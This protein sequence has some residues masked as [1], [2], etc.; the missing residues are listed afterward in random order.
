MSRY[1]GRTAQGKAVIFTEA[2]SGDEIASVKI[3]DTTSRTLSG[4]VAHP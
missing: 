1:Y 3:S 2:I 4:K